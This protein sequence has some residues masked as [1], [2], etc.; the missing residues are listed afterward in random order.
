MTSTMRLAAGFAIVAVLGVAG[1][2]YLNGMP[3]AGTPSPEP[4]VVPSASPTPAASASAVETGDWVGYRSDRYGFSVRLPV[5]WVLTPAAHDWAFPA[6]V[7]WRSPAAEQFVGPNLRISAWSVAVEPG[8]SAEAWIDAYCRASTAPCTGIEDRAGTASL[9]GHPGIVVPFATDT[10][11]F[12]L[13]D[14]RMYVLAAWRADHHAQLEAVISTVKLLP[15]GPAPSL[16]T[17]SWV[18]FTSSRYGFGISHPAGWSV[19]VADRDWAVPTDGMSS[20]TEHFVSAND[21]VLVSAWS[22]PISAETSLEAW[23]QSYCEGT[24]SPCTRIEDRAVPVSIDGGAYDGLLVSFT[25]DVQAIV[26]AGDRVYVVAVWRGDRDST[27]AP[28]GGGRRL[29]E[30]FLSTMTVESGSPSPS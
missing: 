15:E 4:T 11:A 28:F 27:V 20:A 19:Q 5:D 8:T 17:P 22:A 18:P 25:N 9:A 24:T 3:R 1:L 6:D 7:D 12:F 16:D 29:L 23:I 10:Q 2:A 30:A 13:F 14:D 26:R 21:Q